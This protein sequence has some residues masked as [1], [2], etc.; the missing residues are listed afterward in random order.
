M[1]LVNMSL[2]SSSF[3]LLDRKSTRLNPSH[4]QISYAVFC[5]KKKKQCVLPLVGRGAGTLHARGPPPRRPPPPQPQHLLLT[6]QSGRLA[7]DRPVAPAIEQ[8]RNDA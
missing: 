8:A 3:Y 4:S 7:D 6:G 1:R 2:T 5:L